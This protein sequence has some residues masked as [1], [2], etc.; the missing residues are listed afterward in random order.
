MS[1]KKRRPDMFYFAYG[2]SMNETQIS[3]RCHKPKAIAIAR[4]A[5]HKLA[6]FGHSE[7]WDGGE[8]TVTSQPGETLFGV[9]YQLSSSDSDLFDSCQGDRQDGTGAYFHSPAE[10]IGEDGKTYPVLLYKKTEQGLP[11]SP[12]TEH[13]A[14]IIAGATAHGLPQGYID[15]LKKIESQKA[16]YPVPVKDKVNILSLQVMSCDC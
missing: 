12:S 6:F 11:Q 10:V 14:F 1:T 4:L 15:D 9:V 7:T 5:D 13:L 3:A 16:N 8:E 2:A